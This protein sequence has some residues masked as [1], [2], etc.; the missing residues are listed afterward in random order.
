MTKGESRE[1]EGFWDN[2]ADFGTVAE[3]LLGW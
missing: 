2:L 3:A 1:L